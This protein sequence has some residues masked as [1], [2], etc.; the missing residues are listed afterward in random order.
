MQVRKDFQELVLSARQD[1]FYRTHRYKNFGDI[2]TAVKDLVDDFQRHSAQGR[3]VSSLEDMQNFVDSYSEYNA[4]Q[5]NASKHVT[6]ISTLSTIVDNRTLM[7]AP[8][9]PLCRRRRPA[10]CQLREEKRKRRCRLLTWRPAGVQ[11]RAGG[12][13]Q[14]QQPPKPLRAGQCAPQQPARHGSGQAAPGAAVR[15]ALRARGT[16]AGGLP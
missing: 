11:R 1:E 3:N 9:P 5:R 4:A 10:E 13:L 14:Q 16:G 8:A 7:Q 6:L 12:V 15:A 2:G